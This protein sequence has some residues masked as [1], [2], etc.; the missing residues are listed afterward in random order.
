MGALAG[1]RISEGDASEML[2]VGEN[3][4]AENIADV[5][6]WYPRTG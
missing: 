3:I 4:V 1:P 6:G 2:P 5:H